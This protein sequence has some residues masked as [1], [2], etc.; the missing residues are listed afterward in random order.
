M[1]SFPRRLSISAELVLV[2]LELSVVLVLL[3]SRV[4]KSGTSPPAEPDSIRY[5]LKRFYKIRAEEGSRSTS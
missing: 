3:T 1:D 5:G 2:L 4:E